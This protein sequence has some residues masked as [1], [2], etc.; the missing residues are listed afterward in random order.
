MAYR[1]FF[2]NKLKPGVA[3]ADYEAWVRDVAH[4]FAH[5]ARSIDAYAVTRLDDSLDGDDPPPYD[6]VD[7]D[8][9]V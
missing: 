1:V 3:P 7:G 6:F 8:W 9:W 5:G 2:L 4:P